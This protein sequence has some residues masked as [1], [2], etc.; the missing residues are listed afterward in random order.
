[1]ARLKVQERFPKLSVGS[2]LIALIFLIFA[3]IGLEKY[4]VYQ[5]YHWAYEQELTEIEQC[6]NLKRNLPT[7]KSNYGNYADR[8]R[9][10]G[11]ENF[12][13]ELD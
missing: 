13:I 6:Q 4:Y 10:A 1:M 11:C 9:I 7:I 8:R 3:V 5:G 12:V 2:I